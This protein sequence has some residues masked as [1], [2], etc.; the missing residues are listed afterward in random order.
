VS[1][2]RP[3]R[4][5][6]APPFRAS[7]GVGV[8]APA[9]ASRSMPPEIPVAQRHK[10][11]HGGGT[12]EITDPGTKWSHVGVKPIFSFEING[13]RGEERVLPPEPNHLQ[14]FDFSRK[15][16]PL[17][18]LFALPGTSCALRMTQ[19]VHTGAGTG[20]RS[21]ESVEALQ[22]DLDAWLAHYNTE[23]PPLGYRNQGNGP[24][25]PSYD[26]SAKKVK[27]TQHLQRAPMVVPPW[28][29]STR[30]KPTSRAAS[31][32]RGGTRSMVRT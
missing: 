26:S 29:T 25:R 11:R 21:Y 18:A 32:R 22:A 12:F 6:P 4:R 7:S 10:V 16:R 17:R 31:T 19:T 30:S 27:W 2:D 15:K 24:F 8:P 20:A 23:R 14:V 28:S 13:R 5:A 9:C 1:R 3:A